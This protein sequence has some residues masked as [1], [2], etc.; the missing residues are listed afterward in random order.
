MIYFIKDHTGPIEI[1]YTS[2]P[3]A[4]LLDALQT[5]NPNKLSILSTMRGNQKDEKKLH[6][7]FSHLRLYGEWFSPSS[8]LLSFIESRPRENGNP[9]YEPT[10]E[11]S[12]VSATSLTAL[13]SIGDLIA[14]ARKRRE[15]SVSEMADRL[16]VDRRTLTDLE[17]GKFTVSLG[18]FIQTLDFLNLLNGLE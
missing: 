17:K 5:N 3:V 14:V 12:A 11:E 1:G 4:Q 2:K 15:L 8:E 6:E 7:H 13:K 16:G 9:H 10:S 18:V